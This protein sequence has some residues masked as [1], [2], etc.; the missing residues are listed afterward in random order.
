M[1]DVLK[2][3]E[4]LCAQAMNALRE[5][6]GGMMLNSVIGANVALAHY[7]NNVYSRKSISP[8]WWSMSYPQFYAEVKR[9]KEADDASRAQVAEAETITAR[10]NTLEEKLTLVLTRL[11]QFIEAQTPPAVEETPEPE[12]AP[13]KA[14]TKKTQ[15]P[16]PEE[17]AAE[18]TAEVEPEDDDE[19]E[20]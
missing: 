6:D 2:Y 4:T 16:E 17:P 9:I 8:E 18:T 12:P 5:G 3:A 14:K 20:A 15:A 13:V 11:E 7:N 19:T 1:D 10:V